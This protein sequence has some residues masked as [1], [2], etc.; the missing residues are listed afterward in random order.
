MDESALPF[1]RN[2]TEASPLT[3]IEKSAVTSSGRAYSI[4]SRRTLAVSSMR[5]LMFSG[6]LGSCGLHDGLIVQP[7]GDNGG[8]HLLILRP[9]AREHTRWHL[10]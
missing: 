2:G 1:A 7:Y 10:D 6:G 8:V 9:E 4:A 5:S 3:P